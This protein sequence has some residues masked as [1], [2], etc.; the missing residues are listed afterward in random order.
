VFGGWDGGPVGGSK[1]NLGD[2][3]MQLLPDEMEG[4]AKRPVK[5]R[6]ARER[7]AFAIPRSVASRSLGAKPRARFRGPLVRCNNR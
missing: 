4:V 5:L 6:T 2:L 1:W 3:H 7:A